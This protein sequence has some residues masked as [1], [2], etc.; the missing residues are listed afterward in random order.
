MLFIFSSS[1]V[2]TKR[3]SN[4]SFF[5]TIQIQESD[6]LHYMGGPY[7]ATQEEHR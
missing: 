1:A 3:N 7:H 2:N 5:S 4:I 6:L